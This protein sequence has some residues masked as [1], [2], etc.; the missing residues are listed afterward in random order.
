M[1]PTRRAVVRSSALLAALTAV[2][3]VLGFA[4]DAVMAAVFGATSAVD[5]FLVAQGL[6]NLVLGLITGAMSRALIPP[7]TRAAAAGN[8]TAAHRTVRVALTVTITVLLAGSAVMFVA[9]RPIVG[10]LAPG[11]DPATADEAVRATRIVLAATFCIAGT[12][13]LA[14]AAQAHGRFF[15]SGFQGVPFNLIM[16]ACAAG[17]GG[18]FGATALALGFV[19]GSLARL[20]VQLPAVGAIRLRLWPSFRLRDPGFREMLRLAPPLLVGSAILNVNTMVD[21]AVG[22]AQGAGVIASLSYGW[23]IVTLSEVVLVTAFTTTLFPAF[24]TL[25]DPARRAELRHATQRVLGVVMLLMAPLVVVLIVGA[26]PIVILLFARGSFDDRAIALTATA[27]S[28]YSVS[29]AGLAVREVVARTSLAVGDSRN[30]V[31]SAFTAML[32]NVVGDLT[33]GVRFGVAGLAV[34][35]SL[36]V[37]LAATMLSTLTAHRHRAVALRPLLRTAAC[38][39]AASTVSAVAGWV[40]SRMIPVDGALHALLALA[41][42]GAACLLSYAAV[43]LALRLPALTDLRR[44]LADLRIR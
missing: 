31:L 18:Q 34:S 26:R 36:S 10:A 27:V 22:S 32:V 41:A 30:P 37:M 20:L 21:R 17:L 8:P 4:R 7:V 29:L 38:V 43:I 9:A 25:G 16:I 13:L 3:Q 1:K 12:N 42:L 2:S 19:L 40:V 15:W 24:S 23:R 28:F 44:S 39:A 14:A 5:A 35:T 6:A 11:F 33:L